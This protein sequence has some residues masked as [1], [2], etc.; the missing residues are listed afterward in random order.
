MLREHIPGYLRVS[1]PVDSGGPPS[2]DE[3]GIHILRAIVADPNVDL[4]VIPI[5]GALASMSVPFT[6]DIATVAAETDK[7]HLRRLGLTHLGRGVR[8]H[9]AARRGSRCS[10]TS[11]TA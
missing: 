8:E 5:T 2:S 6:R 1:N 4:V 3:R 10:G 7:P 9:P 11:P